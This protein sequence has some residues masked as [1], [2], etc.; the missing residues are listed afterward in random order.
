MKHDA[1]GDVLR[2]VLIED[3]PREMEGVRRELEAAGGL[4]VEEVAYEGPEKTVST[5]TNKGPDVLLIDFKLIKPPRRESVLPIQGSSLATLFKEEGRLPNTPV[6]LVSLGRLS[7]EEPLTHLKDE[8]GS[9][10]DL[11]VKEHIHDDPEAAVRKI[12]AVVAGYRRLTAKKKRTRDGLFALLG[13]DESDY[14]VLMEAEP[15]TALRNDK[16]WDVTDCAQWIRHTLMAYPGILYDDLTAACFLGLSLD[17]FDSSKIAEF[18]AEARY[19][20]PFCDES[21]RWWKSRLLRKATAHM[22]DVEEPGPPMSFGQLWRKKNRSAVLSQC[23]YSGEEPADCVCYL[24]REPV[25]REYSLRYL[26]DTR[27]SVMDEARVSFGAVR[28]RHCRFDPNLV[29]PEARILIKE[30]LRLK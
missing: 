30:I 8:P 6:F 25:R 1:A 2:V 18:F 20:G 4:I 28:R 15:P 14:D 9:F 7:R 5:A 27:P 11:L 23:G 21:S 22:L 12:R 16:T 26:P 10:D 19:T 13:A 17:S 29:G 3:T 24:L